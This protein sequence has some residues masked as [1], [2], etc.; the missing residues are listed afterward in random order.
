MSHVR[1]TDG[2]NGPGTLASG[3][4]VRAY[5]IHTVQYV[6][7]KI[8]KMTVSQVRPLKPR[9]RQGRRA[10]TNCNALEEVIVERGEVLV[11]MLW[12][13]VGS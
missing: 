4:R 8:G 9:S 10:I 5:T 11:S 1:D 3:C 12:G 13:G 6:K 7:K 2:Q